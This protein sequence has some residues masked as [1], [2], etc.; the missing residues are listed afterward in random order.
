MERDGLNGRYLALNLGMA[1]ADASVSWGGIYLVSTDRLTAIPVVKEQAAPKAP[2][3]PAAADGPH[4][5]Q[6]LQP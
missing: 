2:Q 5:A 3:S 6:Q 1:N 4:S